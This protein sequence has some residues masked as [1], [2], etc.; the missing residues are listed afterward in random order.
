MTNSINLNLTLDYAYCLKEELHLWDQLMMQQFF[1]KGNYLRLKLKIFQILNYKFK[2]NSI[3]KPCPN[4]YN[5]ADH[6]INV[7]AILPNF[8]E[9][10]LK[11]SNVGI[12]KIIQIILL[13]SVYFLRQFVINLKEANIITK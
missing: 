10:C 11:N 5:P 12:I 6:Y 2:L 3:G 9:E 1:L 13:I 4:L 7:L 8:R